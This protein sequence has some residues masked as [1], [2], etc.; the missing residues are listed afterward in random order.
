MYKLGGK[1]MLVVYNKKTV[2]LLDKLG[3]EDY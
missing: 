1:G 3:Y 2:Y